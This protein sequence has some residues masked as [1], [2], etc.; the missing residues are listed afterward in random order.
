VTR[1]KQVRKPEPTFVQWLTD[2]ET[3]AA[4]L[5]RGWT[6]DALRDH[7]L[8]W[9]VSPDWSAL[10][11]DTL[12]CVHPGCA[13]DPRRAVAAQIHRRSPNNPAGHAHRPYCE[14]HL[15][16]NRVFHLPAGPVVAHVRAVAK[17]AT[18]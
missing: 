1:S 4:V 9:F 13:T 2:T 5:L 16:G 10:D 7:R 14:L 15:A 8:A 12:W 18:S 17:P 11:A 6:P 3:G